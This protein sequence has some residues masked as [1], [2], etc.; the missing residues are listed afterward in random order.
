MIRHDQSS[1]CIMLHRHDA[2]SWSNV[3]TRHDDS[4][5]FVMKRS[6]RCIVKIH[7]AGLWGVS[8][9]IN[10]H[11][12]MA[13]DDVWWWRIMTIQHEESEWLIMIIYDDSWRFIMMA[14]DNLPLWITVTLKGFLSRFPWPCLAWGP[15]YSFKVPLC[16]GTHGM[17]PSRHPKRESQQPRGNHKKQPSAHAQ[18]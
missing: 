13:H 1:W 8:S 18:V 5:W 15:W 11:V 16:H 9:M 12:M 3:V 4:S 14:H 7:H 2:S 17:L 10:H 6:S